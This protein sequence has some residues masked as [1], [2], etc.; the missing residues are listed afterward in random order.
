MHTPSPSM[1]RTTL[2][3]LG[4]WL[5]SQCAICHAWPAR[6]VCD[7]CA[8]RFAQPQARCTGCALP[9]PASGHAP[10]G[11]RCGTCLRT[12]LGLDRC[13]AAV[14]YAYP[15]A[16]IV[17]QYKFQA[18]PAWAPTLARLLHSTPWAEPL[19]DAADWV[20]PIP[21]SAHRLRERG[22]NQA[23]QL[24]QHWAR[25]FAQHPQG[26]PHARTDLLL[27]PQHQRTQRTL[28]RSARLRNLHGA[29]TVRSGADL[30]GLR[31]LVVDDVI[32]TGATLRAACTALQAAGA[33]HISVLAV[34]RT[35]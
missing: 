6:R 14:D 24:T 23:A 20:L 22:F 9:L 34:A 11:M 16:G 15:W 4:A 30:A 25:H 27:R 10:E 21:L 31:L 17:G 19:M 29:F 1:L 28:G 8:A 7:A 13:V 12:P 26:G 32:T 18:D 2:R 3:R 35:P 5:P 33:Q